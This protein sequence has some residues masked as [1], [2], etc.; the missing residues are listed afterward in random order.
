MADTTRCCVTCNTDKPLSEFRTNESTQGPKGRCKAC[1]TEY[2]RLRYVETDH[3]ANQRLRQKKKYDFYKQ[4]V[5][6]YYGW[7]CACCG[8]DIPQ[9]LS[10]DHIDNDGYQHRKEIGCGGV[11]LYRWLCTNN[12][13]S[14]FQTLCHN[15]NL[16]KARNKGICPHKENTMQ[17]ETSR[18]EHEVHVI[19]Q[20]QGHGL[21]DQRINLHGLSPHVANY[22]TLGGLGTNPSTIAGGGGDSTEP[23]RR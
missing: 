20:P 15:C 8:E 14:N 2:R 11:T 17:F 18:P 1:W 4:T 3:G 9:F 13:P 10:I 6:D 5:F 16:G 12:F 21:M 23:Y 19:A 7:R 22:P